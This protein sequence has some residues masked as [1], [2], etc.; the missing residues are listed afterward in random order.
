MR[1][2]VPTSYDGRIEWLPR[3]GVRMPNLLDGVPLE[4]AAIFTLLLVFSWRNRAPRTRF[5]VSVS[6][7]GT[8]FNV[9]WEW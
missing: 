8:A 3:K 5:R 2:A 6:F 4:F 7:C 1:R 9:H